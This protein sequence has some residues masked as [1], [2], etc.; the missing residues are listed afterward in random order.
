VGR[1]EMRWVVS[2]MCHGA[3]IPMSRCLLMRASHVY[4]SLDAAQ[5]ASASNQAVAPLAHRVD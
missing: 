1:D 3:L 2:G 4:D 5:R